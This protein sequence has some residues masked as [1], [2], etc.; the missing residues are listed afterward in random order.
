MDWSKQEVA[1]IVADYFQMLQLEIEGKTFNKAGHNRA[2]QRLLHA[3]SR[4]SIEF[5][6]RN[7]SA[8]L[9]DEGSPYIRGYAP[10]S[11]YQ[12]VLQEE[13][14]VHL[15][16]NPQ[17]ESVFQTFAETAPIIETSSLT[18]KSM[19]QKPPVSEPMVREPPASHRRPVKVNYL[20]LE[21]ANQAI[22]DSG[23]KIALEYERW[24]LIREGKQALADQVEWV[25]HTQGDGLGFDILSRNPNGTDRYIEVKS[26]KLTKES[27]IFFSRN[28]YDFSNQNKQNYFLY[29]V[30]NLKTDPKLFILNGSFENFCRYEAVKYKGYF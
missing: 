25:A 19:L 9:R 8:V 17:L 4:S 3:R 29:R 5:K 16:Q 6:H 27:P 2:L 13:V 20:E 21:Q 28:E 11:N 18:F 23:E 24:R 10:L 7:I 1:L 14:L 12:R 22:G 30:F 26:T 15:Q